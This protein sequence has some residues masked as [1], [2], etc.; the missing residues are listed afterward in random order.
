MKKLLLLLLVSILFIGCAAAQVDQKPVYRT[1]ATV[2]YIIGD[3]AVL[4][5]NDPNISYEVTPD[6][7]LIMHKE[8]VFWLDFTDCHNCR[9]IKAVIVDKAFTT[10][11]VQRDYEEISKKLSNRKIIRK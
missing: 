10:F 7:T 5:P 3:K 4:Q 2:Q 8:Y 6:S 9:T 1:N 11:Q